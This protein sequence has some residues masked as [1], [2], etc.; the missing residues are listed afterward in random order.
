MRILAIGATL[1]VASSASAQE[2]QL[3]G[4]LAGSSGPQ[5]APTRSWAFGGHATA[6]AGNGGGLLLRARPDGRLAFDLVG[7]AL[8][9]DDT[10]TFPATLRLVGFQ[11]LSHDHDFLLA[12]GPTMRFVKGEQ[13]HGTGAEASLG[14]EGLFLRWWIVRSELSGFVVDDHGTRTQGLVLRLGLL[15]VFGTQVER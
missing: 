8:R 11:R 1:L 14:L 9:R 4:P 12:L 3:T 7:E 15:N 5:Y 6:G 2:I 10:T 13:H